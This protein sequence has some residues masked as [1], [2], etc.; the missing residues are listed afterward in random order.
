MFAE[1]LAHGEKILL[2]SAQHLE[3]STSQFFSPWPKAGK[4]D[5]NL[6]VWLFLHSVK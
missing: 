4:S 1:L 2:S 5:L 6:E 3:G